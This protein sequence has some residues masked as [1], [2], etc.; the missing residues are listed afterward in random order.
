M[1]IEARLE[2]LE[3]HFG[4]GGML[5]DGMDLARM[6]REHDARKRGVPVSHGFKRAALRV[7]GP[8]LA[9]AVENPSRCRRPSTLKWLARFGLPED[10]SRGTVARRTEELALQIGFSDAEMEHLRRGLAP[11]R[12]R[13]V[14]ALEG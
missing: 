6:A 4:G 10:A 12:R 1:G 3:A 13:I 11:P 7:I 2:K 8:A 5:F 14:T 9:R